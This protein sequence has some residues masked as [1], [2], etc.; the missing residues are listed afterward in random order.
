MEGQQS[1]STSPRLRAPIGLK[2]SAAMVVLRYEQQFLLLNRINP[3]HVG[4]YVPVGGK[5]EPFES[6]D[7]AAIRETFEE[8]GIR[9]APEQ[10]KYG[11]ILIETAPIDYNWQSNIYIADVPFQPAPPCDEG[12]LEWIHFQDIPKIPTPATDWHI[13]QYLMREQAFAINAIFDA[14]LQL[15]SMTEEIEGKQLV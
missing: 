12:E 13:Y 2:R 11:G 3:P 14:D 15:L 9:I 6:P 1:T 4:K 8:T 10:L 5:L 7:H